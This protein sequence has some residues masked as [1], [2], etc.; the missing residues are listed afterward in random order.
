VVLE[1]DPKEFTKVDPA[2]IIVIIVSFA[3][4]FGWTAFLVV[5][6]SWAAT[7]KEIADLLRHFN[8]S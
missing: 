5:E 7:S 8:E 1:S 6:I 3:E 2:A 4:G